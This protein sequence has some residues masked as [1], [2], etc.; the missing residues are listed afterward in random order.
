MLGILSGN[1]NLNTQFYFLT[2]NADQHLKTTDNIQAFNSSG[3]FDYKEQTIE[4]GLP[5]RLEHLKR[6]I[7]AYPKFDRHKKNKDIYDIVR[8]RLGDNYTDALDD[9]IRQFDSPSQLN[10]QRQL[11]EG[12]VKQLVADGIVEKE[13]VFVEYKNDQGHLRLSDNVKLSKFIN[14][15]NNNSMF[16]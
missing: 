7:K 12:I 9:I 16:F 2:G 3:K 5:E 13:R 4:K 15:L 1:I 10:M 11:F 8:R 14:Y 6:K